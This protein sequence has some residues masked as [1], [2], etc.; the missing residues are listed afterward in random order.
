MST[1]SVRILVP[2]GIQSS[3]LQTP[4]FATT[5]AATRL[6]EEQSPY[7]V[8]ILARYRPEWSF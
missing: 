4:P 8:T 7:A 6:R 3:D 2:I 1:A 5:L